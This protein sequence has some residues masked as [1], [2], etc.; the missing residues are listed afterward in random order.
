[1]KNLNVQPPTVIM[2]V[3]DY[4]PTITSFIEVLIAKK[5][6]YIAQD[7]SVLFPL[8]SYQSKFR[9]G[10]L[11]PATSPNTA[12]ENEGSPDFALWKASKTAD[13]PGWYPS[14]GG[15]KGRPGW[16]VRFFFSI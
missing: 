5:M 1:M 8:N 4:I 14:W 10:K 9:Y 2:R 7:G 6:A 11:K 15:E 3:S 16:H 12:N 13:E